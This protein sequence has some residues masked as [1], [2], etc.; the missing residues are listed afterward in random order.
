MKFYIKIHY[1]IVERFYALEMANILQ[2][3]LMVF[4]FQCLKYMIYFEYEFWVKEKHMY[5]QLFWMEI[6]KI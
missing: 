4:K 2:T 5:G 6:K 1:D 3:Q